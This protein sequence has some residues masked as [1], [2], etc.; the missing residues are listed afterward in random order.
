M[1]R[2]TEYYPSQN[3]WVANC[4]QTSADKEMVT[5]DSLQEVTNLP[6]AYPTLLSPT[7]VQTFVF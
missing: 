5:T 2:P 3:T 6:K 4:D 1:G 7:P